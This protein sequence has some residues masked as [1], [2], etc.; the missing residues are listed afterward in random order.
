MLPLLRESLCTPNLLIIESSAEPV[1]SEH[2]CWSHHYHD[3][4]TLV[5]VFIFPRCLASSKHLQSLVPL[6]GKD[7]HFWVAGARSAFSVL[8][9][10]KPQ[11]D[12]VRGIRALYPTRPFIN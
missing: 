1:V 9:D 2:S 4:W 3:L 5:P 12:S 6:C 7:T 11:S 10:Q 8:L